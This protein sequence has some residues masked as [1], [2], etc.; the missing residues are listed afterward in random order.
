MVEAE[1]R[2]RIQDERLRIARDLHDIVAHGL[3]VIAIQSGVA[4][5]R[6][7]DNPAQAKAALE[8][9]N[10]TGRTSLEDLRTM[11]GALRSTDA[12]V[13]LP[14]PTDPNDV[15]DVIAAATEADLNVALT[16]NGA[17]P[18]NIG[19]AVVLAVHRILQEALM[20]VARHA[21]GADATVR[22]DHGSDT[23]QLS[24]VNGP[25][26]RIGPV[27]P[28]TGVGITGMRERAESVGGELSAEPTDDGGFRLVATVPYWRTV[29]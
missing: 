10:A 17:F 19:D 18:A 11:V 26:S 24:V 3:S 28:S 2:T 6:I 9:I 13:T 20:N 14:T 16:T 8:A 4:A 27:V 12:A 7:D 1:A 23:V 15:G 22:I 25:P 21:R 5:R 29:S